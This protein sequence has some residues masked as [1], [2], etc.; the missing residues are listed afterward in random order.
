MADVWSCCQCKAPNLVAIAPTACPICTHTRCGSCS[1]GPPPQELGS[2]GP[3]FPSQ[4]HRSGHSHYTLS[5]PSNQTHYRFASPTS[6]TPPSAPPRHASL[7]TSASARPSSTRGPSYDSYGS[8]PGSQYALQQWPRGARV[9]SESHNPQVCAP[10]PM[11]GWWK[12]CRDGHINN[13][14]LNPERCLNDNH[15]ICCYCHVLS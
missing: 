7:G 3:L 14:I 8:I 6:Y 12:C 9:G 13:P 2:P 4:H 1:T 15:K 5:P 10:Q 11:T